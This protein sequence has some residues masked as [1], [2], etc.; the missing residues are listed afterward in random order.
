MDE[1]SL[2]PLLSQVTQHSKTPVRSHPIPDPSPERQVTVRASQVSFDSSKS[3]SRDKPTINGYT[4][5]QLVREVRDQL[6]RRE[7]TGQ[8]VCI[9]NFGLDRSTLGQIRKEQ[10]QLALSK[11]ARNKK[12]QKQHMITQSFRAEQVRRKEKQDG[13]VSTFCRTFTSVL[14]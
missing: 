10:Q 11:G 7:E 5:N 12:L 8:K 4:V 13:V 2:P 1:L 9:P 6:Q 3:V 14:V